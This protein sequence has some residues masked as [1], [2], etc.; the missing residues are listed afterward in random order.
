ME[1]FKDQV[2][3]LAE[4]ALKA[5]NIEQFNQPVTTKAEEVLTEHLKFNKIRREPMKVPYRQMSHLIKSTALE[6]E[7][8]ECPKCFTHRAHK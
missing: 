5:T 1:F 7:K 6:I 4:W 8:M 3:E 2:I